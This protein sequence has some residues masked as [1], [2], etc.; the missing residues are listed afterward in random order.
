MQKWS[1]MV[2]RSMAAAVILSAAAGAVAQQSLAD[3]PDQIVTAIT[4]PSD[5]RQ[6]SFEQRG[7]LREEAVKEGQVVKKGDKLM[8]Q[9]DRAERATLE[10]MELE[11]NSLLEIEYAEKD[12][13]VQ[14][15]KY[16]R[17]DAMFKQGAAPDTEV[18]E[19]RLA[20]QRAAT[21]VKMARQDKDKKKLEAKALAFR[22]EN[23]TMLSPIDGVV[24]RILN[25]VG[26]TTNPEPDRPSIVVVQN[27][28]LWVVM[29]L[30]TSQAARVKPD[31]QFMV[32]YEG[33]KRWSPAKVQFI[34]PTADAKS[35][36]R[37]VRLEIP[38]P[39]KVASGHEVQVK[40]PDHVAAAGAA[41]PGVASAGTR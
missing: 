38:N 16:K 31:D 18:D 32:R 11:A 2:G 19:A 27:D 17:I 13:A 8:V 20:A 15:S 4:L 14:E 23:M 30:P 1:K 33:T 35:F 29:H 10:G 3:K 34:S 24:E 41:E 28:P 9:E 26:E 25:K 36:K 39:E 21:Q 37:L 22:I 6:L 40:L 12:Q 7:I 5:R